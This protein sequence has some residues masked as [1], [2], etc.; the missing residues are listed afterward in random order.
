[1]AWTS[2]TKPIEFGGLGIIDLERFS[3]ALRLRWLWY[4]WS[5]PERRWVGSEVPIDSTDMSLF[6]AAT[7][8]TIR[9]GSKASF[10][11]SSWL[12]GEAPLVRF[13]L[14]YRHSRRKKRTVR[15]ALLND[16]W[17]SDIAHHL[18]H[19]LPDEFFGLW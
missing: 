14:L 18:Y 7:M 13:P 3:R 5:N 11:H 15:Q 12:N 10:W 16:K 17:I 1:M 9:N 2:V 4:Q 6:R 8:V 19:E